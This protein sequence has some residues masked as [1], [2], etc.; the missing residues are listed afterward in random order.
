MR[1]ILACDLGGTSLRVAIVAMDGTMP[2]RADFPGQ[3]TEDRDGASEADAE[4]WWRDF[5]AG[6]DAVADQAPEAFAALDA[7]ALTG[8][9]RTQVLAGSD[10]VALRPAL[11][12]KDVRAQALM[13]D[14]DRVMPADH[15]DRGQL[16]PYH[17]IARLFWLARHEPATLA[18]T[19]AV[20]E[21]K[22]WLAFRLTGVARVD[23]VGSARLLAGLAAARSGG[24]MFS[25]I[26]VDPAVVPPVVAPARVLGQVQPGGKGALAH[27]AGVP[28]ISM[29]H[30][31]W[32][33]VLGLGA[34][35][36]G[37]AYNLSGT[38]EVFGV[39]SAEPAQAEGLMTVDWGAAQQLGGP[40]LCGGDTIGWILDL[41]SQGAGGARLAGK[42]L[43]ALLAAPR[44]PEPVIFLP[45]LMGERTPYWNPALRGAFVGLNRRHGP[46]DL[47]HAVLEGIAFVNRTVMT[48]AEAATGARI[49]E[50]RFGGGGAASEAW[51]Q[52][53]ADVCNRPIALTGCAETGLLGCAMAAFHALG[54]MPTLAEAQDRLA[55][56]VRHYAPD[57]ARAAAMHHLFAI[58]QQ[59]E[60]VLAPVSEQLSQV[61]LP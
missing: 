48:R 6:V 14:L 2:A 53:K 25:A 41:V 9:T 8:V 36:P 58:F 56:V 40:S 37:M 26:G 52:I 50:I 59:T 32:A 1:T 34:L 33:S 46:T 61:R 35:R 30:D 31:T 28:V 18:A 43:G 12:W 38:T 4:G 47:A 21:P 23:P 55:P 3:N 27:L 44:Q 19:H 42:A 57:P 5:R 13:D 17:P 51:C 16:N 7:I 11:T 10:G 45:Y 49:D 20:L 22:D 54:D 15:P 29:G 24:T 39:L 60:Q